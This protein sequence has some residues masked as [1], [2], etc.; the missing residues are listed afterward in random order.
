MK[1]FF[2]FIVAL[3]GYV[4]KVIDMEVSPYH[5]Y[6]T[7]AQKNGSKHAKT[8]AALFASV[9]YLIAAVTVAAIMLALY[10]AL[11]VL[12]AATPQSWW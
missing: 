4:G 9:T 2:K 12:W 8:E 1:G 6:L 11:V 7:A 10:W 5:D 3:V